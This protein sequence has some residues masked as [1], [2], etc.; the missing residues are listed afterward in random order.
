MWTHIARISDTKDSIRTAGQEFTTYQVLH[1]SHPANI[2]LSL[3]IS[4]R[5][6]ADVHIYSLPFLTARQTW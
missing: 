3:M 1:L 4:K 6:K 5:G 2:K